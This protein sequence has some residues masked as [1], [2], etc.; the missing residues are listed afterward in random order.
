MLASFWLMQH[1]SDYELFIDD[2]FDHYINNMQQASTEIDQV[3]LK[4]MH[5]VLL[6]QAGCGLE[7]LDLNRGQG[8]TV[9]VTSFEPQATGVFGGRDEAWVRLLYRP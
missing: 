9:N 5:A 7:V 2:D 8:N 3:G 4:A 6:E 1:R